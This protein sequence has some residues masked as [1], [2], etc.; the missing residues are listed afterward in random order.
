MIVIILSIKY[1]FC[2]S[3]MMNYN[4]QGAFSMNK[5]EKNISRSRGYVYA[6][7][8]SAI[9]AF[10]SV[11]GKIMITGGLDPLTIIF[12]QS[13]VA[14]SIIFVILFIS[15]KSKFKITKE[16]LL[17][18]S[19][20]GIIGAFGTNLFFYL[21][22]GTLNAGIVSM[23]LFTN[24][25]FVTLYFAVTGTKKLEK[26]NYASLVLA[27][28]GAL[29]VLDIIPLGDMSL[30]WI[31][32]GFGIM[33]ALTYAFY[34]IYADFK[35]IKIDHYTVLFYTSVFGLIVS[36]LGTLLYHG[37]IPVPEFEQ[38]K[39]IVLIALMG[40]VLPIVF[41]YKSVAMIGSE[42]T[43]IIATLEIPL[44]LVVAFIILREHMSLV[45]L[46]GVAMVISSAL[47]LHRGDKHIEKKAA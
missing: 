32:I 23:L 11:L 16:Q 31:G 17:Q 39:Y 25:I 38:A 7:L 34:N 29:F 6:V 10:N 42:R 24:P 40:G 47:L 3:K 2:S 30:S 46:G 35:M 8:A 15:D 28:V 20:Q 13:L 27:M 19:V 18:T 1:N 36:F 14:T 22:L 4:Y 43:S 45:Q 9:Y 12:Y 5:S 21:A 44:T 41:F 33:S 37:G 26:V